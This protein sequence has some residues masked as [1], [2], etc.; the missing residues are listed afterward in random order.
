MGNKIFGR[1]FIY[2]LINQLFYSYYNIC[3]WLRIHLCTYEKSI[4]FHDHWIIVEHEVLSFEPG[5]LPLKEHGTGNIEMI[6]DDIHREYLLEFIRV[7]TISDSQPHNIC[8]MITIHSTGPHDDQYKARCSKCVG[9][10]PMI[11][12]IIANNQKCFLNSCQ[13]HL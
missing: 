4:C 2:S 11:A 1:S 8:I 9:K 6:K 5:L 3:L 12:N 13:H 10:S 7:W